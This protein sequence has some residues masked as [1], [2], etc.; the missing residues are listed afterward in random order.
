MSG[1]NHPA[2]DA[3]RKPLVLT[4]DAVDGGDGGDTMAPAAVY[5][6][7]D[8]ALKAASAVVV[9][10]ETLPEELDTDETM[11]DR[12]FALLV[13]IADADKDGEISQDEADVFDVAANAAWDFMASK[14]AS[15]DDLSAIFNDSDNDAAE[16][17]QELV[18]SNLPTSYDAID[19]EVNAFTFDSQE[20]VFDAVYKKTVVVK[21]GK[22]VKIKKRVSGN[23]RLSAAQ[24]ASVNK[25]LRKSHSATAQRKRA[26]SMKIRKASGI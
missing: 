1:F 23:V 25:M 2:F 3:L 24:K 9:W 6:E 26:K 16:R 11:V 20:P 21:N 22:K 7:Q 18:G 10:A 19:A 13:G 4:F 14:G 15:E 17:V 8:T 5:T 12:L